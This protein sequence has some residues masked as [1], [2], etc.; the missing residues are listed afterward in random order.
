MIAVNRQ[1]EP[2]GADDT[3]GC[4]ILCELARRR[5]PGTYVW[6]TG[7]EMGCVGS[8]A[9][10]ARGGDWLRTI[11][12]VIALDRH[13]T[14]DIITHQMCR[15]TASDAFA[16][17]LGV[18]LESLGL[19]YMPSVHGAYTDS[20][21]YASIVPECTNLSVGYNGEHGPNEYLDVRHTLALLDALSDL[22]QDLPVER[23][24][25][26]DDMGWGESGCWPGQRFDWFT[27]AALGCDREFPSDDTLEDDNDDHP[28]CPFCR[29]DGFRCS[30]CGF[31][32][33]DRS[34]C[35]YLDPEWEAVQRALGRSVS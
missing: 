24:P 32:P 4:F 31:D 18:R 33:D 12:A 19:D 1:A 35:E 2:L 28:L 21:V 16:L 29:N 6:H 30:V 34:R 3:A 17:E 9:L 23:T 15:R 8:R 11:H 26:P 20:E 13:G 27:G 25:A 5:V 14:Q 10:V 22:P 7:E